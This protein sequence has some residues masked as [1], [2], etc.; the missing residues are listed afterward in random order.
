MDREGVERGYMNEK[1]RNICQSAI[2]LKRERKKCTENENENTEYM[3]EKDRNISQSAVSLKRK[4][5]KWTE[6]ERE[7]WTEGE[8]RVY[9]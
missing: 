6:N 4:R 7:R 5:K 1:D 3:N 9:E 8:E 2:L